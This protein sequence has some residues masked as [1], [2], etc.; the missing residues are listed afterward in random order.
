MVVVGDTEDPATRPTLDA[1][2]RDG[3]VVQVG[4]TSQSELAR[5][6]VDEL[7]ADWIIPSSTDQLWWPR[8]ESLTDVLDVV[9]PRYGVVQALVRTFFAGEETESGALGEPT[10][11]TSLLGPDG[12]GGAPIR[13]LLRPAYRAGPNMTLD[14]EDWTLGGRRVPLRAWY[15]IE[16]LHYPASTA[17]AFDRAGLESRLRGRIGR[18][19][20]RLRDALRHS[21]SQT[22]VVPSIVE[23]AAYAVE[24]AALG[25]ADFGPI[26]DHVA[27]LEARIA[28]L[29]ARF[30]P[31]CGRALR[32]LA[33]RPS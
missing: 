1:H 13:E 24:C 30:W 23:D 16:V 9:P 26:E 8:G 20:T 5:I 19:L 11:R 29:E 2:A 25:E 27:D 31:S 28:V 4:A 7:G 10:I 14:A 15:P 21:G 32:R 3:F 18:R 17:G 12:S 22:F 6:A 33:R